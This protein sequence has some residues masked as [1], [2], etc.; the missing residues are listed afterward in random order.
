MSS[1]ANFNSTLEQILTEYRAAREQFGWFDSVYEFKA[2]LE[3]ELDEFWD[4]VKAGNPDSHELVQIAAT[5]I[6][7]YV[8][9][10]DTDTLDATVAQLRLDH[11]RRA[12]D[13]FVPDKKQR[14]KG[15]SDFFSSAHELKGVLDI[16]WHLYQ[17]SI[18]Y[19][20]V[21]PHHLRGIASIAIAGII[22]LSHIEGTGG[23]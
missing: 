10:N 6:A 15:P 18:F 11:E 3:E 17:R 9:S 23:S 20:P 22:W 13:G 16:P 7:G 1:S 14:P 4:S 8:W 5:A 21:Q 2:V 12:R 19:A